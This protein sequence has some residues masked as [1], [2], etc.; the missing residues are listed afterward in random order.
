MYSWLQKKLSLSVKHVQ[1]AAFYRVL[2]KKIRPKVHIYEFNDQYL[3]KKKYLPIIPSSCVTNYIA[4]TS[5]ITVGVVQLVRRPPE[6]FPLVGYWLENLKVWPL[7]R[8]MGLG[9]ELTKR[10]IDQAFKEGSRELFLIIDEDNITAY[11]LYKNLGF[12]KTSVPGLDEKLDKSYRQFGRRAK[13]M[14]KD[15]TLRL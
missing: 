3:L 11:N 7:W 14:R 8:R 9:E 1:S 4:R 2:S 13:I 5:H 12:V 10:V 15:L 6:D